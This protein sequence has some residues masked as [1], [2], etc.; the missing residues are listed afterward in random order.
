MR[1]ITIILLTAFTAFNIAQ[2]EET[3]TYDRISLSVDAEIQVENDTVIAQMFSEREGEQASR[4]ASEVNENI[5]WALERARQVESVSVQ[6]TAYHSQPVYQQQKV[7]GWRVRQSIKLES[8]DTARLGELIGE[9]QQ[10]LS[11]SSI[12][13][14]ISPG[15]RAEAQDSL[16]VSALKSFNN[17]AKLVTEQ[18][19]RPGFRIVRL[20]IGTSGNVGRPMVMGRA[21]MSA[22]AAPSGMNAPTLDSGQQMVRVNVSGVIELNLN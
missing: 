5:T 6:T 3:L 21:A 11:V 18:L 17:R 20:D 12:A 14:N 10:K 7:V 8:Q 13:Y 19:G 9:L 2:A 15:R 22:E 1:T 4:A 16:I